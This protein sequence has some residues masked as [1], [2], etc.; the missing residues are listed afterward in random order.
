M[1]ASAMPKSAPTAKEST[2]SFS[3]V[4]SHPLAGGQYL[5]TQ[6]KPNAVETGDSARENHRVLGQLSPEKKLPLLV[7]SRGGFVNIGK[8][9]QKVYA[10][11]TGSF[12][13]CAAILANNPVVAMIANVFLAF[14]NPKCPSKLFS[15]EDAAL[16]WLGEHRG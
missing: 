3:E 6:F 15:S 2:T 13:T 14:S 16:K 5:Y 1:N 12:A 10:E 9:A 11:E 7:D 4:K 8:E